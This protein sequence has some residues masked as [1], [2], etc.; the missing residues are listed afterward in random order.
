[1]LKIKAPLQRD[2]PAN[3]NAAEDNGA[4]VIDAFGSLSI[5]IS[6]R[7]SYYGSIANSWYFLQNEMRETREDG[8]GENDPTIY[9]LLPPHILAKAAA[10]P[11]SSI[12]ESIL[13]KSSVHALFRYL[14][15]S[16]KAKELRSI[17][18]ERAAWMYNPI[19]GQSF[20][21]E[22]Y[23]H[24]Y[25]PNAGPFSDEPMSCHRLSVMFMV[26][27]IGSLM[28]TNLPAYNNNA[29]VYHQLAKAALFHHSFIDDPTIMAVQALFLMTY[30]LF[31]A[32]R[33][34]KNNSTRWTIMGMAVKIAQSIGLHRD[35]GRWKVGAEETQRR[36][37]LFWELFTYDSWQCFSFGRPPSF[38]LPH[39]DCKMPFENDTSDE[40]TF[41]AWKHRFASEC[42]NLL[43]DQAFGAKFPPYATVIQLDRKM[44]A[45]PVP[46][47]LQVSCYAHASNGSAGDSPMLILQRHIVLA[48]RETSLLYLHRSFFA[49]A[50]SDHP[51]DPL[52]SPY[53]ASVLAA[54]RSAGALVALMRN[55]HNQLKEPTERLWWLWTH[56]FSCAIVLGSIVTRCPSIGI[57]SS[58]LAQLDSACEL[59]SKAARGFNANSVLTIMLHLQQKAYLAMEEYER[60]RDSPTARFAQPNM[61]SS[62]DDDDELSILGGKTRL[63]GKREPMSPI[64]NRSPNSRNPVVPLP[65]PPHAGSQFDPNVWEYLS[66]FSQ[67]QPDGRQRLQAQPAQ[68]TEASSSTF[69]ES[70][71]SMSTFVMTTAAPSYQSGVQYV[72][73]DSQMRAVPSTQKVQL[74]QAQRTTGN[75]SGTSIP[76]YFPVYDYTMSNSGSQPPATLTGNGNSGQ[77]SGSPTMQTMW[78]DFV[79]HVA[80]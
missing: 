14:P 29:E 38:A 42:M 18:F 77:L 56:M 27:A 74:P 78:Q 4:E 7:A 34:S 47:L 25:D 73:E 19:S 23:A 32:D 20:D 11:I 12:P 37:E 58:A 57:A 75:V 54:Y 70:E 79:H 72:H 41:H 22:I 65:L 60:Q 10:F 13:Q 49:R 59:F 53:G 48:I 51:N 16:E 21:E 62:A 43:H 63:A 44:R 36:R 15:P 5:S 52:G 31:L 69:T 46:P 35:S 3:R 61:V 71:P 55:L 45:F 26:M 1:L 8:D 67:M 24:F 17:Y 39:I 80:M 28:D 68:T 66:S 33:N 6:G 50:I 40:Q 2:P 9:S 64:L 30:Y 76:Q